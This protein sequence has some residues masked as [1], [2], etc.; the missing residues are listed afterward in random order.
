MATISTEAGPPEVDPWTK[1]TFL[2]RVRIR[3]YKSI[4]SCDVALEPLTLLVGRNAAGKSN[5]LGALAFLRDVLD[6]G[7][8]NAVKRQG[9]W[10]A[11]LCRTAGAPL[12]EIEVQVAFACDSPR[13]RVST[14]GVAKSSSTEGTGIDLQGRLFTATYTLQVAPGRQ[15]VP[16]IPYERLVLKDEHGQDICSFILNRGIPAPLPSSAQSAP[17]EEARDEAMGSLNALQWR[18]GPGWPALEQ[19][20]EQTLAPYR[21]D[22]TLLGA[23]GVSPLLDLGDNLRWMGF[24]NVQPDRIRNIRKPLAG[25]L[26]ERDGSNLAS[27]V[28]SLEQLDPDSFQRA[29]EYLTLIA[30]EVKR[31]EAI[32]YGEYETVRFQVR[33]GAKK[34]TELDAASMSDGTLRALSAIMAAFQII[35][36]LGHPSV[37]GIEEPETALH[38]AAMGALVDALSEA[39][40]HTQVL[41]TTHSPDLL[42][43]RHLEAPGVVVVRNRDG[44]TQIGPVDPASREI[45][46]RELYTLADLHRMDQLQPDADKVSVQ[47][48]MAGAGEEK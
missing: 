30:E 15:A 33:S 12:I 48:P 28:R 25:A 2:R 37:V 18:A 10:S 1:P 20:S 36:P 7:A 8:I 3:G 47:T 13:P 39:T 21:D 16:M 17:D 34:F 4:A 40:Q 24:Y 38:P 26:L 9:G 42:G 29:Q 44:V 46:R 11:I 14:N 23:C 31:F 22:Q 41:L 6:V 35:P 27:I 5:F 45:V 19:T 32:S 43:D